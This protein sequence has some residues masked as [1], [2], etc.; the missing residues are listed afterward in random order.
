MKK[1]VSCEWLAKEIDSR[2]GYRDRER[3]GFWTSVEVRKVMESG[4]PNW[5][6]SF[7]PGAVPTGFEKRWADVRAE[8]EAKFDVDSDA[9]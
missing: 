4:G 6:Y 7:N 8:F 9:S 1:I 3:R 2:I 5:R